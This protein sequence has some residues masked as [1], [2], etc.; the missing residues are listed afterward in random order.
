VSRRI[1]DHTEFAAA[2]LAASRGRSVSVCIPARNEAETI[3]PIVSSVLRN[4]SA[5]HGG[6]DLVDEVIVVD[7]SS[8]D[9]TAARAEEAGAKV[10]RTSGRQTGKGEA[11]TRAVEASFGDV[12]LFL[13]GDVDPFP[14]HFVPGLLG[15]A[16]TMEVALVKP[17]YMRPLNGVP[18]EGGRVT[19][20]AARPIISL[21]FPDLSEIRQPLAG[22]TATARTVLEK[23]RL[24]SGYGVE[25]ALL[26]DVASLFGPE[27]IVQVDLGM[28]SHRNRTLRDLRPQS[29][30]VLRAALERGVPVI[31]G[32][33][34]GE[35]RSPER[36][37]RLDPQ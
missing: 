32:D 25:M 7:D 30:D 1:F 16:L 3:G 4:F 15:P 13:D 35:I 9:S 24:A 22:E 33:R 34:R 29:V 36:R 20:L 17:S 10:A 6:V 5:A 23:V 19:E 11:M 26:L 18:N 8:T 27:S 28:R 12:I 21:L 2:K 37:N 14:S 31:G